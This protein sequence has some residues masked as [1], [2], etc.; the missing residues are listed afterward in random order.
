MKTFGVFF[1][2]LVVSIA[3]AVAQPRKPTEKAKVRPDVWARVQEKGIVMVEVVLSG[4]WELDPKLTRESAL[5]QR[6]AIATA[7]KSLIAELAGTKHK[8]LSPSA[9]GPFISFE[10]GPDALAVLERS[11]L[12]KDVYLGEIEGTLSLLQSVPLVKAAAAC[13]LALMEPIKR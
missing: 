12:V 11:S 6:Q 8:V 10:V 1:F 9:I 5:V 3:N 13:P 7:Q 2:I 4:K